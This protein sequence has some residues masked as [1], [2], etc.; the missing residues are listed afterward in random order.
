M[1]DA[2]GR[3]MARRWASRPRARSADEQAS[4]LVERR[5]A[6]FRPQPTRRWCSRPACC[7]AGPREFVEL[8]LADRSA[9]FDPSACRQRHRDRAVR[10]VRCRRRFARAGRPVAAGGA[11][12]RR[13]RAWCLSSTLARTDAAGRV[14]RRRRGRRRG[15]HKVKRQFDPKDL[16]NPGR[17]VYDNVMS[18]S[19]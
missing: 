15:W 17:F 5:C 12:G 13:H 10:Q 2:T 1:L 8:V 9:S 16:L 6:S 18:T 14:G 3:R 11:A 7:P 19:R 4:E